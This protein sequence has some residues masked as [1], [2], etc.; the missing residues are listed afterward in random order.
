M[1]NNTKIFTIAG[2]FYFYGEQVD[3]PEGY[4]AL[5]NYAMFGGFSGGKGLP[6]VARGDKE[7][8]VT[9][10]RFEEGE[11]GYFPLSSCYGIHPSID[12]YK[13]KGTTIR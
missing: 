5:N 7:A 3:A 11:I 2:G 6:G 8:K 4:I 9:L 1:S 12:L 10:D 13:F